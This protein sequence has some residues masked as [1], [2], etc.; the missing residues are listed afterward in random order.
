MRKKT[1]IILTSYL[2][3]AVIALGVSMYGHSKDLAEYE[4]FLNNSYQH[5]FSELVTAVNEIDTAL[6]KSIYATSPSM[7]N[8]VCTQL[9][10]KTVA[11]QMFLAELPFSNYELHE[12][13]GF[14][15]KVGDYAYALAVKAAGGDMPLDTDIENLKGLS[16]AASTLSS[17]LVE[18]Q[19]EVGHGTITLAELKTAQSEI[20]MSEDGQAKTIG[21]SFKLIESEFPETPTLIYDGPYSKHLE[22]KSPKFIENTAE[23]GAEEARSIAAAFMGIEIDKTSHIGEREGKI[24]C[25][26]VSAETKCGDITVLV[27]KKGGAVLS[28]FGRYEGS[29]AKTSPE[30]GV[31]TAKNFLIERGFPN[32]KESYWTVYNNIAL[33]NFAY[34]QDDVICYPDLIKVAVAL[35]C[36]D[37]VGFEAMGFITNHQPRNL[38]EV[39]ITEDEARKVVSDELEILSHQLAVIPTDGEKEVLCHEYKCLAPDDRHFI[40]YVDAVTG[41]EEEILMLIE[42]ESGTLTL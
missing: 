31:E 23:I 37:V 8:S 12:T 28:A 40:V 30:E 1:I 41:E 16:E 11:A 25:Y 6:T 10:G 3:A 14:L 26:M 34:V 7:L 21:E 33:I 18:L 19:T 42:D 32:M 29:E 22:D 38:P 20:R 9:F 27:T 4:L 39:E 2:I 15:A 36:S 35:D 5:S 17:K 13:A 24:P